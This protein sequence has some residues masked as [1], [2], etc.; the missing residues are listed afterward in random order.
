MT[1]YA[2]LELSRQLAALGCVSRSGFVWGPYKEPMCR[3]DPRYFELWE[4][5]TSP[6][7]S[8]YDFIAPTEQARKNGKL[9]FRGDHADH[10]AYGMACCCPECSR[11]TLVKAPDEDIAWQLIADAVERRVG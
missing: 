2:S 1:T 5:E 7:F 6:A 9:V 11:H 4:G 8:L 10:E 3:V